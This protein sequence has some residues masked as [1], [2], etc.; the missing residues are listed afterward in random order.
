[1]T[2]TSHTGSSILPLTLKLTSLLALK[3]QAGLAKMN[4]TPMLIISNKH[5]F[6]DSRPF[7]LFIAAILR[8]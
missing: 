1:F 6:M 5:G 4:K 2:D 3:G 7:P 8:L